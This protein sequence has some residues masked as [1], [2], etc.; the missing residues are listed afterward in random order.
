M[1]Q[2][3]LPFKCHHTFSTKYHVCQFFLR[4]NVINKGIEVCCHVDIIVPLKYNY[5]SYYNMDIKTICNGIYRIPYVIN[6]SQIMADVMG[7]SSDVVEEDIKSKYKNHQKHI[8]NN[9]NQLL[10]K[11]Q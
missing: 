7:I 2:F 3:P 1:A 8:L 4:N 5:I 11:Q 9:Q 10:V 6:M